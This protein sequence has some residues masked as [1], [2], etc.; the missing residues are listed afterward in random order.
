MIVRFHVDTDQLTLDD[1]I[2]L[3]DTRRMR[4]IDVRNLLA[5]F[6]V[7]EHRRPIDE[8]L[9]RSLIGGLTISQLREASE[10]FAQEVRTLQSSVVNP[11]IANS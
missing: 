5:R 10:Q 3:E 2:S 7:D 1:L 4:A 6:V 9:A 11:Q 8:E